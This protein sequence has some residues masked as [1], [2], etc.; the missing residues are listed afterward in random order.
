[1]LCIAALTA[2]AG[3]CDGIGLAD[4]ERWPADVSPVCWIA[5]PPV[6]TGPEN[7]SCSDCW[8]ALTLLVFVEEIA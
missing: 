8:S 1:M 6:S 2:S 4:A 7:A 3:V 5:R